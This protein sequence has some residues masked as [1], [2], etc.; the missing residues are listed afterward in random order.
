MNRPKLVN[1]QLKTFDFFPA[2]PILGAVSPAFLIQ[3]ERSNLELFC[4]ATGTPSPVATWLKDGKEMSPSTRFSTQ[5][6]SAS[7]KLQIE[8]LVKDDQGVYTCLF[9]NSVAQVSHAMRL[10]VEGE[11]HF[12]CQSP[13]AQICVVVGA[14]RFV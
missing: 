11:S 10:I 7:S 12:I 13:D 9:K 6:S 4:E 1:V 8:H 5:S 14:I 2:P 3:N